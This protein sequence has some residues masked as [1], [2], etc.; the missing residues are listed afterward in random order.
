MKRREYLREVFSSSTRSEHGPP[1]DQVGAGTG[2]VLHPTKRRLRGVAW[3]RELQNVK[4]E[5]CRLVRRDDRCD[6]FVHEPRVKSEANRGSYHGEICCSKWDA[7]S[8]GD[9]SRLCE[10]VVFSV[11]ALIP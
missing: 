3:L 5:G 8:R 6:Q 11:H 4:G 9:F 7:V 1:S 10:P 2:P